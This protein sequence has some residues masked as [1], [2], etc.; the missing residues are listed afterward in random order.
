MTAEWCPGARKRRY[1]TA[2]QADQVT[3]LLGLQEPYLCRHGCGGW[4]VTSKR[5]LGFN[6]DRWRQA[7]RAKRRTS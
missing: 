1:A 4:H 2:G 3:A 5:M 7:R 6:R